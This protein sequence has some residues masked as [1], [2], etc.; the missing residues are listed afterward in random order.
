MILA[1]APRGAAV[2]IDANV[3][4]YAFAPDPDLGAACVQFL[5]RIENQEI[6]GITTAAV[7]SDIAHRFMTLEACAVLGWPYKGIASRLREHPDEIRRL[8]RYRKAMEDILAIG[9][10]VLP[11]RDEHVLSAAEISQQHGLL[12]NDALIVAAMR[13]N[14]LTQIASHDADFDLVPG[15][16]RYAPA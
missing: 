14:H 9:V 15:L 10:R 5:E 12:S 2:F 7:F 11:V 13:E 3:F 6:Q 16:L 4:I 1:D 8:S